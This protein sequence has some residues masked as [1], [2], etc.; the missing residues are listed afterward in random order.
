M[1]NSLAL[2]GVH[3]QLFL[4]KT[5][6]TPAPSAVIDA[7][8]SLEVTNQDQNRDGFQITF[9]LGKETL[10]DYNLLLSG[11]LNPPARV[12]IVLILGALPQVLIDGIIT[13]HQFMPS[14]VPGESRL[15][16]TGEDI[17]LQLDLVEKN[18]T[19]PNQSDSVI[20]TRLLGSY[21][22]YDLVPAVTPTTDVPLILKY[23]SSQ[24]GTDLAY[25]QKLAKRHGF[26]FYIEPVLPFVNTAY[27]GPDKRLGLPQSA[28]TMN[29]GPE[30]NVKS[31]SFSYDALKPVAPQVTIVDPSTHMSIPIPLPSGIRPPLAVRPAS[32]LRKTL[33]RDTA[34][35]DAS[36]AVGE[37]TELLSDSS[38]AVTVSGELDGVRYGHVLRARR[39]VGLRGVGFNYDGNYYV[40]Q[41]THRISRGSYTQSFT[42]TR[43]GTGALTPQ[44]TP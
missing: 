30:S 6:P 14:P 28:L 41:V 19:Y 27:W 34:N 36:Q 39:L 44:V 18:V 32:P 2:L 35:R 1:P 17:S 10:L 13:N 43:E 9:S 20:V 21:A 7:L 4:G 23:L 26:V 24:Q 38:D 42:L 22:T 40:K 29:M 12:I 15:T 33:A 8:V 37:A 16:V 3:L 5:I 25:I 31:L 11:I